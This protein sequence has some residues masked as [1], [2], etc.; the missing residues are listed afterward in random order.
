M[1]QMAPDPVVELARKVA[2]A[3]SLGDSAA[4]LC[5]LG[6]AIGARRM[7]F[8]ADYAS[9]GVLHPK[10]VAELDKYFDWDRQV[11]R[12]WVNRSLHLISPIGTRCRTDE[13]PFL[14]TNLQC[15]C[16]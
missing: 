8:V 10:I 13:V 11:T 14:W 6:D 3:P 7:S 4:H 15:P 9:G 12:S 5:A 16:L 1:N 2:A